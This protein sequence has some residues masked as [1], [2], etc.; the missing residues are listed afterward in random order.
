[1]GSEDLKAIINQLNKKYGKNTINYVSKMSGI[2]VDRVGSGSLALDT[3][4]GESEGRYGWPL[5]R[6]VE[7]YGHFS[8]G[9]SLISLMTIAEAQKRD[10]PCVYIDAEN[11][12]D[13]EFATK[14]GVDVGKLILSQVSVG[15]DVMDILTD[16]IRADKKMVI[17]VDSVAGLAPMK[18]MEESME[19]HNIALTARLMSKAL[20]KVTALNKLALIIFINQIRISPGAYGNPETT[21]GGKALGHYSSVRV[22][23]RKGEPLTQNKKQIGQVVKFKVTKNKTASPY[24]NGYFKFYYDGH[25]DRIDELVTIGLLNEKIKQT[26]AMYEIAGK[27]IRGREALEMELEGDEKFFEKVREEILK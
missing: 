12:F 26:G 20:R 24:G 13:P 7:L 5:G 23:V 1:M 22:E 9:K 27:K 25:I 16:V 15:E 14:L 4:L 6:M 10:L 18:E 17:V 2:R 3:I 19:Q 8:S 11:G 21:P